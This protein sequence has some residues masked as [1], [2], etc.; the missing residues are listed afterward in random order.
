[1]VSSKELREG[2]HD[3]RLILDGAATEWLAK[4]GDPRDAHDRGMGGFFS[5]LKDSGVAY[6]VCD[7]CA[8]IFKVREQRL[9][10]L[11]NAG[12]TGTARSAMIVLPPSNE[13][14]KQAADALWAD[15]VT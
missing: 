3:V 5:Q 7:F 9:A 4:W 11:P 6:A 1:M 13:G 12:K 2:G 8:N 14:K 15:A 10:G